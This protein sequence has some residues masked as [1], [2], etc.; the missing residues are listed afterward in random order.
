LDQIAHDI[1]R[2][3]LCN[4]TTG[5][6]IIH[7]LPNYLHKHEAKCVYHHLAVPTNPNT[8]KWWRHLDFSLDQSR[9]DRQEFMNSSNSV[10][11]PVVYWPAAAREAQVFA[12][13]LVRCLDGGLEV[14]LDQWWT[15]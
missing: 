9:Q 7:I 11:A 15:R 6:I 1:N 13:P 4:K 8:T 10:L 14:S 3:L 5:E 2:G 12:Y